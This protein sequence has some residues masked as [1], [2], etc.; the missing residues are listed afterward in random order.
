MR[1]S[2]SNRRQCRLWNIKL[3]LDRPFSH[4][5]ILPFKSGWG[6]QLTA[7][8]S[9]MPQC[10]GNGISNHAYNTKQRSSFARPPET[11][12]SQFTAKKIVAECFKARD[13]EIGL[14]RETT[15]CPRKTALPC[16]ASFLV[17]HSADAEPNIM[18][19]PFEE[20]GSRQLANWLSST[21]LD[22]AT[23]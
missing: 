14:C 5:R 2:R 21:W 17:V 20:M 11:D 9:T 18:P 23:T 7:K 16:M 4:A 1:R 6:L 22:K 8:C 15:R 12:P 19:N 10:V 13:W 3:S